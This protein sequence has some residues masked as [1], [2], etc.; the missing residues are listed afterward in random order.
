[1]SVVL[2]SKREGFHNMKFEIIGTVCILLKGYTC[3]YRSVQTATIHEHVLVVP[4]HQYD[5]SNWVVSSLYTI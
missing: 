1:M 4:V 3:S 2:V 5:V